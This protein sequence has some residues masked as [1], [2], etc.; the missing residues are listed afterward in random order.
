MLKGGQ[1][2]ITDASNKAAEVLAKRL[3]AEGVTVVRNYPEGFIKEEDK[4]NKLCVSYDTCS[5]VQVEK[6]LADII[7]KIGKINY[8]IHTDNVIFRGK[9]EDITEEDFKRIYNRNA[10]SAFLTSKVIG[11]YI[12]NNGGGSILFLSSVHDE[13]PT[14]CAFVYSLGR[15]A[16]KMLSKELGL[17]YGR[18]GVRVNLIEMDIIKE[19]EEILDSDIS[20]FNYDAIT[21]IP[22]RRYAQA[23]DFASTAVFLLSDEARF[24]NGIEIRVDGGHILYYGDR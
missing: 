22:M 2:L 20:P 10:K 19:N 14:G 23:E 11:D 13:K 16:V 4:N 18:R 12:A 5:L 1:A 6:L 15:G 21:K 7:N 9:V 17:F 24:I 8:L 3:E